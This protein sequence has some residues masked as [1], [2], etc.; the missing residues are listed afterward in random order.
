[1]RRKN[2]MET[3]HHLPVRNRNDARRQKRGTEFL[4]II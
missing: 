4:N 1:M 2:R 3:F